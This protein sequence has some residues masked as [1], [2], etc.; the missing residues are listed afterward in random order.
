MSVHTTHW[1]DTATCPFCGGELADPG[2]GFVT[3]IG[4]NQEC[5]S[6]F[7]TWRENVSS[8]LGGTWSG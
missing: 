4:H 1:N 2:E 8:D 6:E 5:R 3:H 7:E